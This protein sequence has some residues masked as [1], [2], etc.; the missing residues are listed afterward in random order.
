MFGR[1]I[2]A[3]IPQIAMSAGTMV[4]CSTKEIIMGTHSNIGPIDPHL[5]DIPAYGVILEFKR[6]FKETKEDPARIPIWQSIIGQYRPTFLNQCE[7]AIRWLNSFVRE[8][9][10]NVM[11]Y[12]NKNKTYKAAKVVRA[13][14][15]FR[16]G[17]QSHERHLHYEDCRSI[18][19]K[20]VPLESDNTFQDLVLTVHHCYMHSLM[21]TPSLKLI[22]NH[23]GVAFVKQF[24]EFPVAMPQ[25]LPIQPQD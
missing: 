2:R 21:N 4:A 7:D 14:T 24:R 10:R 17:R 19:L 9:L 8:Q 18:G 1:D 23:L 6:A 15:D 16:L 5:R 3:I 20:V 25:V 11:F 13:L 12:G 22:E